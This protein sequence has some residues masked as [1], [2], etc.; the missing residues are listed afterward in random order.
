MFLNNMFPEWFVNS[1]FLNICH[2]VISTHVKVLPSFTSIS[3][4][5]VVAVA[6]AAVVAVAAAAVAAVAV[7]AVG[8]TDTTINLVSYSSPPAHTHAPSV[9]GKTL[10]SATVFLL[11][12]AWHSAP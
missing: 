3:A 12:L 4:H 10:F 1:L 6:A 8:A 9:A 11:T 2:I 7:A 5:S